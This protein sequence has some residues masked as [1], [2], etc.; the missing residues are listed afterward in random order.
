MPSDIDI[1]LNHS[2]QMDSLI[3]AHL[4]ELDAVLHDKAELRAALRQEV[5]ENKQL[6][7]TVAGQ[8]EIIASQA[9]RIEC[10]LQRIADLEKPTTINHIARDYIGNQNIEK[11]N[12]YQIK[13]KKTRR[14]T[15]TDYQLPELQFGI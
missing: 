15:N 5:E 3:T 12:L 9:E 13:G 6:R 7:N 2:E 11:V 14:K 1:L 10:L 8:K 4:S